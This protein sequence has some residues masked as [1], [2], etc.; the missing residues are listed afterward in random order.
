MMNAMTRA[1]GSVVRLA[2][3]LGVREQLRQ[4]NERWSPS[5]ATRRDGRDRRHIDVVLAA[6]LGP[7]DLGVDV[8]ANVGSVAATMVRV[9]PA[10]PHVLVEPLPDLAARLEERFPSCEVH[11]VALADRAGRAP[12]VHVPDRPTR[13]GLRP[14]QLPRGLDTAQI[15][16]PVT[17][18]DELLGERSP[19]VL[20]ID[21]EGTE[22]DV[23]RGAES[24]LRRAKPLVLF[25][26]LGLERVEETSGIFALF[27]SL[28][29]RVFDI[30][31]AGPLDA[32]TFRSTCRTGQL[33]NFLASPAS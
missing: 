4:I 16:V 7:R 11:A 33:W 12:F 3:R 10:I 23:L 15:E 32:D 9:A 5:R 27:E 8:G 30:D 19:R 14:E 22:L 29:Y 13:S 17:T 20:K 28:E 21:V 25:E 24:T 1:R 18:L 6:A 26:H 2:D 31:G